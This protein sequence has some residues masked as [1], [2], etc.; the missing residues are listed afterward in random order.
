MCSVIISVYN[1]R[2]IISLAKY[3]K[4]KGYEILATSGTAAHLKTKKIEVLEISNYIEKKEILS[5]RVKTIDYKI[6][7]GVLARAKDK[8]EL[9]KYKIKRI[10]VVVVNLY[11]FKE[12][13]KKRSSLDNLIENIDIG[14][15]AL[16]RAAAK[17]FEDTIVLPD[18]KYYDE[19]IKRD[20][21]YDFSYRKY[22]AIETFKLT[23]EY[24][25]IIY[26]SL[27]N[28]GE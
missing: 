25:E 27:Q 1:K 13:A 19:F 23:S 16:L 21:Q 17:N 2:G 8:K 7:A 15:V 6:F 22:L 28:R 18:P 9:E 26:K 11:P 12:I 14:G 24:D 5:G 20:G 10:D 4:K 3:L